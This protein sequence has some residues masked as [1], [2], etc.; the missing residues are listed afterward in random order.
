MIQPLTG[1][2]Q[3]RI[4]VTV[5][6]IGQVLQYLLTRQASSQKIQHICHADPH[7]PDTRS[8]SALRWVHGDAVE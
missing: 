6:K 5:L 3:Y 4:D 2:S 1:E 7:A 8:P